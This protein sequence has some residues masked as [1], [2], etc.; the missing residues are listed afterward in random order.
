MDNPFAELTYRELELISKFAYIRVAR[1]AQLLGI[2]TS[3]PGWMNKQYPPE[4][5]ARM[6]RLS[7]EEVGIILEK[8][9]RD[10]QRIIDDLSPPI[11]LVP[12][13]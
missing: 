9:R 2:D 12:D 6:P 10:L 13:E 4:I 7:L 5:L 8:S 3:D 11:D 1:E